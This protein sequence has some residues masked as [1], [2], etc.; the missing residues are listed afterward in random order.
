MLLSPAPAAK[1]ALVEIAPAAGPG[2]WAWSDLLGF[3]PGRDRLTLGEA[4]APLKAIPRWGRS[5]GLPRSETMLEFLSPSESFKDRGAV[6]VAARL[7]AAG[8][9]RLVEDSSGNA[10]AALAA[11]CAA[12]GLTCQIFAPADA[13]PPK[14]AQIAAYGAIVTQTGRPR[15]NAAVAARAEAAQPGAAYASHVRDPAFLLGM[16]S[17]LLSLCFQREQTL[18]DHIVF[19]TGNGGLLLGTALALADIA[20]PTGQEGPR[21]HA[22]QARAISPL[23]DTGF[24][25]QGSTIASG[26]AVANPERFEQISTAVKLS[27]GK[28]ATV[29][30]NQIRRAGADLAANEGIYVEPTAAAGFAAAAQ[31]ASAGLIGSDESVLIPATGSGLKSYT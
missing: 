22:A 13:D 30:D 7:G 26:I 21:L 14:L 8:F 31:L 9:D 27:G 12:A 3:T 11:Y 29:T 25:T 17:F 19:P 15:S 2:I 6:L 16:K 4:N 23:A 24:E 28:V 5:V 18:P 1:I 10:G 20:L